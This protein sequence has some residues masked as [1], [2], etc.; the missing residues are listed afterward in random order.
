MPVASCPRHGGVSFSP[1]SLR[2]CAFALICSS[3]LASSASAGYPPETEALRGSA[4]FFLLTGVEGS[5]MTANLYSTMGL[6]I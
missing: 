1:Y 2:L 3:L 4:G 5:R 6:W